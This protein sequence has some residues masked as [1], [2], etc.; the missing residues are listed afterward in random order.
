M[1]EYAFAIRTMTHREVQLAVDWA[2]AEGWNPGLHDAATYNHADPTGFLIGYLGET[3]VATISV[4]RYGEGFGFLGFYIVAPAYRGR[5]YGL[6]IWKAGMNYLQGRNVGLDGVLEQQANYQKFG[7][8]L[9]YRNIRYEGQGGWAR[10]EDTRLVALSEVPFEAIHTYDRPFFPEDRRAFLQAWVTQPDSH[11]YA[12]MTNGQIQGYGL[13][14]QCRT[15]YKIGPLYADTPDIAETVFRALA[16][17][18]SASV[19]VFLDVPETNPAAVHLA[20]RHGMQPVFETA[21]MYTGPEPALPIDRLF[22]VTSFEI[23]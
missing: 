10:P 6:Q 18:T 5:G 23:G 13:I 12:V 8:K 11:G 19:P 15:G 2:A 1:P 9:A 21:R 22:G 16:S 7:F 3:P 4:V 14:R 20:E 17:R